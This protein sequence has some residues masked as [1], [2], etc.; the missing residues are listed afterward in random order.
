MIRGETWVPSVF[1]P[2]VAEPSLVLSGAQDGMMNGLLGLIRR[3]VIRV[4]E[5]AEAM[6]DV[7]V[8]G[9]EG[10]GETMNNETLRTWGAGPLK[11][12]KK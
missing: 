12:S 8:R 5:L 3:Q 2:G 4:E 9:T 10:Y 1:D 11:V 6:V 7:V